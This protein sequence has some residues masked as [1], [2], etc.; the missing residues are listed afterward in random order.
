[1]RRFQ[2]IKLM[3]DY[4]SIISLFFKLLIL[5]FCMSS[6]EST[7][8]LNTSFTKLKHLVN[9]N[10]VY[11]PFH[12]WIRDPGKDPD[13]GA[14]IPDHISESLEIFWVKNT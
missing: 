5:T 2:L 8:V 7:G 13:P 1:M 12:P 11:L 14:T 6:S 4:D 10:N 9:Y 3:I